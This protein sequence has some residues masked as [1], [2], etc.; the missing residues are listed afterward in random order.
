MR[1]LMPTWDYYPHRWG[2]TELY[3]HKLAQELTRRGHEITIVAAVP[4]NATEHLVGRIHGAWYE[5]EGE[6]V[7]G[8]HL[9]RQSREETYRCRAD[10]LD[11][12][13]HEWLNH[14]AFDIVHVHGVSIVASLSLLDACKRRKLPMVFTYHVPSTCAMGTLVNW[15][16]EPCDGEFIER[17]CL[18]CVL[19]QRSGFRLAGTLAQWMP[20]SFW[21]AAARLAPWIDG[22]SG[23][24]GTALQL[25]RLL[26]LQREQFREMA[27]WIDLWHVHSQQTYEVLQRNGITA[28][29]LLLLRHGV[30]Q[31]DSQR[32][33]RR[34]P[35]GT[36]HLGFIGRA[37]QVKGL[38]TLVRALQR[39]PSGLPVQ[40]HVHA[41]VQDSD[42]DVYWQELTRMT[43]GDSRI[44]WMGGFAHDA[45]PDVL[46]EIDVL[47]VPSESIE[48]GPLVVHEA[49]AAG[50]PVLGSNLGGIKE[51]VHDNVD[52]LL[53]KARDT[54]DLARQIQRLAEDPQLLV[55]LRD[56]I[57]AP[58]SMVD[59]ALELADEYRRLVN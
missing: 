14:R 54:A 12:F 28:D 56:G 9:T 1:I 3:I 40:L 50:V 37:V 41:A 43:T 5:H 44:C 17:R 11:S 39:L 34:S 52:G 16:A 33:R 32:S 48:S 59:V 19:Q 55:R 27:K 45:L 20:T 53:F 25:P 30:A 26:G 36:L 22:K 29:R 46:A 35:E 8:V 42:H 7:F 23:P 18:R 51:L 58:A 2:G 6:T 15:N 24:L 4:K 38:R 49:F 57:K 21:H 10:D 31:P 13:W 47:V